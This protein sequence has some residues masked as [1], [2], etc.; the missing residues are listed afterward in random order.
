MKDQNHGLNRD[1]EFLKPIEAA[2]FLKF[3]K[4][5]LTNWRSR[6]IGPPYYKRN[7]R[8]LYKKSDLV[9]YMESGRVETVPVVNGDVI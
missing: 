3:R 9:E 7:R 4:E 5:T 1:D 8:V 2:R 6:N